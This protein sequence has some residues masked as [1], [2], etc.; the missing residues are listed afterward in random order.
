M[1]LY[2]G[3][4]LRVHLQNFLT[5]RD[6]T[7]EFERPIS[8][9]HGSNGAGKSSILQAIHFALGGRPKN[10]RDNCTSYTDLKTMV[11]LRES[12][13]SERV[14]TASVTVYFN[15]RADGFYPGPIIALKR[16]IS[17]TTTSYSLC[18]FSTQ[19]ALYQRLR[20]DDVGLILQRMNHFLDNQATMVT[21]TQMKTLARMKSSDRYH[22]FAEASLLSDIQ[23]NTDETITRI[24]ATFDDAL[25]LHK[26]MSHLEQEILEVQEKIKQ[27][28]ELQALIDSVSVT[29]LKILA[30]GAAK[31]RV[32]VLCD[33]AQ[34]QKFASE[35]LQP[36]IDFLKEATHQL[37]MCD[38]D[39]EK[40]MGQLREKEGKYN[41]LMKVAEERQESLSVAEARLTSK[42]A[43]LISLE[44]DM[45]DLQERSKRATARIAALTTTLENDII[46]SQATEQDTLEPPEQPPEL[47][48]LDKETIEVQKLMRECETDKFDLTE[49]QN[50]L[51]DKK[52][53]MESQLTKEWNELS[54]MKRQLSVL[55]QRQIDEGH[56]QTDQAVQRACIWS[57]SAKDREF[58]ESIVSL[59]QSTHQV[60]QHQLGGPRI[61]LKGTIV[62]PVAAHCWI[63]PDYANNDTIV[64]VVRRYIR[65]ADL[66]ILCCT[67]ESDM[68]V[69]QKERFRAQ[70]FWMPRKSIQT[71][72]NLVANIIAL[73]KQSS[74]QAIPLV[75]TLKFNND[76]VKSCL[77]VRRN[78]DKAFIVQTIANG[79]TLAKSVLAKLNVVI[80]V[81]PIE[82][83]CVLRV[84]SETSISSEPLYESLFSDTIAGS[85]L[86]ANKVTTTENIADLIARQKVDIQ[87]MEETVATHKTTLLAELSQIDTE[88]TRIREDIHMKQRTID[89]YA[90]RLS[91]LRRSLKQHTYT[92]N[93]ALQTFRQRRQEQEARLE[94]IQMHKDEIHET[95]LRLE[96]PFAKMR[97]D[98]EQR[99]SA[100]TSDVS[101]FTA[102]YTE[103]QNQ[104]STLQADVDVACDAYMQARRQV[105]SHDKPAFL[106]KVE[107]A[108]RRVS[109]FE[110]CHAQMKAS[111]LDQVDHYS[112]KMTA[113][114]DT[115]TLLQGRIEAFRELNA[116]LLAQVDG[117]VAETFAKDSQFFASASDEQV[118]KNAYSRISFSFAGIGCNM[119]SAQDYCLF[120][121]QLRTEGSFSSVVARI[122]R[123]L[124]AY[125]Q[126]MQENQRKHSQL[127][128][129]LH[130]DTDYENAR[131]QILRDRRAE[132]KTTFKSIR[133]EIKSI[134]NTLV[135]QM[136]R[137][138]TIRSRA[139]NDIILFFNQNSKLTNINQTIAF[140]FP[141][142]S[143][144]PS[145]I[146]QLLA[147]DLQRAYAGL[148]EG[149]SYAYPGTQVLADQ[150]ETSK[151][152]L[153]DASKQKTAGDGTRNDAA[154][155]QGGSRAA[156]QDAISSTHDTL[157]ESGRSESRRVIKSRSKHNGSQGEIVISSRTRDTS[158]YSG[159]EGTFISL[160]FLAACWRVMQARYSQ[161]D[162]WD[163]FMDAARRKSAF[164]MLMEVL[165]RSTMQCVLVTPNDVDIDGLGS[166]AEQLVSLIQL[167][168]TRDNTLLKRRI[169]S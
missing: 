127:K 88:S 165:M 86:Y 51:L 30:C 93:L 120:E 133:L 141:L 110:Q 162:E 95:T 61:A 2:T 76:I 85:I 128:E 116:G 20:F 33:R 4:V 102:K 94:K 54:S 109:G 65:P 159:G 104:M 23:S 14:S 38:E 49:K 63:S 112:G 168:S 117:N 97:H 10:I 147:T 160:C 82:A 87:R 91:E 122:E 158:T 157:S 123:S 50:S 39:H 115:F 53:E 43:E 119:A 13:E 113:F 72:T 3:Y 62:G 148:M 12:L 125:E 28:A 106:H 134:A 47:L 161:I 44:H 74:I 164:K 129:K 32:G 80:S 144:L 132:Q 58:Y 124:A 155:N 96:G 35:E 135:G 7:I 71:D 118:G 153:S 78:I 19:R 21:Q 163:V 36:A 81:L 42:R 166:D 101:A 73:A 131:L 46:A 79:V 100:C 69:L 83:S 25:V 40:L 145:N 151:T 152:T 66:N 156:E 169:N 84:L 37:E 105:E 142:Y 48:V 18:D 8:L 143:R 99:L 167:E 31:A 6:K 89:T 1:Y 24:N 64:S 154:E 9:V 130:I 15:Y 29:Q 108:Q 26:S 139:E 55:Q 60:S 92:Y 45:Q 98:Y 75:E 27:A 59:Q 103:E 138:D 17:G 11:T 146:I 140:R 16:T 56:L 52:I 126:D 107:R 67:H 150:D 77:L 57:L 111:L 22:I 149:N 70:R 34:L 114:I 68:E 137:M 41:Q 136:V 5:H 90:K 121:R